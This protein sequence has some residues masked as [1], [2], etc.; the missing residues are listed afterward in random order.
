MTSTMT[1]ERTRDGARRCFLWIDLRQNYGNS[2]V[3]GLAECFGVSVVRRISQIPIM[4]FRHHPDFLLFDYDFPD[5]QRLKALQ[6]TK[7][8]NPHLPVLMFTV[9][10]SEALAVWA[11]RSGVREYVVNPVAEAE[12]R[13]ICKWMSS[14]DRTPGR[15]NR[16]Q[17]SLPPP[18]V[19]RDAR[20]DNE[21]MAGDTLVR[22]EEYMNAHFH[23]KVPLDMVASLVGMTRFE[24]SRKFRQQYG[25]TFREYLTQC[26]IRK[27]VELLEASNARIT[28]VAYV[29]GI[30]DPAYFSRRFR[31]F[32]GMTPSEYRLCAKAQEGKKHRQISPL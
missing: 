26:R 15:C 16:R 19:P 22:A 13:R 12:L 17:N 7:V 23:E 31:Q 5:I 30:R 9:H 2:L 1:H 21:P 28:D 4:I 11:Y 20:L 6:Q 3:E 24:F 14:V 10:H 25:I 32:T 18:P 8:E 27:A 29:V